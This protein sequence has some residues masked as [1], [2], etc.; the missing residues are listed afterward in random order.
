MADKINKLLQLLSLLEL[1]ETRK[2]SGDASTAINTQWLRI[3]TQVDGDLEAIRRLYP[4]QFEL[5]SPVSPTSCRTRI[6]IV[7]N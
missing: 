6:I 3:C 1:F 2:L 5:D 4:F 7:A